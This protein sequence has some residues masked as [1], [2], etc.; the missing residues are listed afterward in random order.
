VAEYPN[1]KIRTTKYTPLNFLPLALFQQLTNILYDVY[2]FTAVLQAFPQFSVNSPFAAGIPTL[3]NIIVGMVYEG[4]ADAKRSKTDAKENSHKITKVCIVNGEIVNK[5]VLSEELLVGDIIKL[6]NN[7]WIPADCLILSTGDASG[8]CYIRTDSLD[9]ERNLKAK[10]APPMTQGSIL[11]ELEGNKL[12]TEYMQPDKNLWSFSG[13]MS[14]GKATE[15]LELKHFV[16]RGSLLKHSLDV[17]AMVLYTGAQTKIVLN[18]G[19]YKF[20]NSNFTKIL[21]EFMLINLIFMIA[22]IILM[23]QIMNRTWHNSHANHYYIF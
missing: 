1:N 23:S 5:H 14:N 6:E 18:Q 7:E 12:S 9:G 16:P 11:K 15:K 3:F 13:Q 21:N 2:I 8:A 22:L 10:L 17:Y 20:K 19:K 4:N